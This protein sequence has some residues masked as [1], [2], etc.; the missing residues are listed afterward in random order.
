MHAVEFLKQPPA[1]F[2]AVIVLTGNQRHFKQSVLAVLR[3]QVINDDDTSLTRFVGKETD[4]QSV[5]DELRTLSMW[6]DRR[7]VVVDE[8]DEFVSAHRAGLE[9]YV[10]APAKKSVLVIDAVSWPKTTR[11]AKQVTKTGLEIDCSALK[12]VELLRW[13]NDLATQH[14]QVKLDRD[15]AALLVELVGEE[16]GLLDQELSK[17][18]SYVGDR[19]RITLDDVRVL[20]GGWRTETTWAMTDAVRDGRLPDALA[21]LDQLLV[22]GEAPQK[23]LGGIS[24]VFRKLAMATELSRHQPFD[25]ALKSAGVFPRD[26]GLA[27][28]YLK[29]IGR[30]HAERIIT[31][32]VTADHGLKGGSRLPERIQME[33]LLIELAGPGGSR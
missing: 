12:G 17:V 15:A 26:L 32:I 31:A 9:K 1:E 28:R 20:V 6:G 29:R 19:Q 4:L 2:P 14:Y 5:T 30:N 10:E 27:G 21:A 13:I 25:Q 8:A 24:F 3:Q 22:A 16:P 7:L 23:L 33:R 11:I 18:A